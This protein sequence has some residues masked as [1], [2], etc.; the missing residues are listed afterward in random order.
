MM[1]GRS[2]ARDVEWLQYKGRF[3]FKALTD[4]ARKV[5]GEDMGGPW[6]IAADVFFYGVTPD[7]F[8]KTIKR[9]RAMGLSTEDEPKEQQ[10]VTQ[11]TDF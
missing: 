4:K 9:L 2:M 5:M 7:A 10:N 6:Q 3:N 11:F 8:D 1:P